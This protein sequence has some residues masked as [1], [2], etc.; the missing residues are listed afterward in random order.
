[1]SLD[2]PDY[3]KDE[4]GVGVGNGLA[5]VYLSRSATDILIRN[6]GKHYLSTDCTIALCVMIWTRKE[7]GVMASTALITT[8]KALLTQIANEP[9]DIVNN[10][11]L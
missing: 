9:T 6:F 7:F 3:L 11:F 4:K 1:M 10:P 8:R 5:G 2:C